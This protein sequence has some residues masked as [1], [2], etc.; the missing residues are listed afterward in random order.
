MPRFSMPGRHGSR[1]VPQGQ[2]ADGAGGYL[3]LAQNSPI[4]SPCSFTHAGVSPH[5]RFR[6]FIAGCTN[7]RAAGAFARLWAERSCTSIPMAKS[8]VAR[9]LPNLALFVASILIACGIGELLVRIF[10]K[11][12]AVLFPRYHTA[13]HYDAFVLRGVRPNATFWHESNEGRWKFVT[14]ARGLRDTRNFPYEKPDSIL[15][16]L[17]LGDS[18][19]QGY[20]TDQDSTFSAVLERFLNARRRPAQVL[21]A[22]VSG[23]SNAE[24]LAYLEH[25]GVRYHP[26]VVVLGFYANDLL[27]NL[28]ADLYRLDDHDALTLHRTTYIPGVRALEIV[29]MVPLTDYLSQH[30]YLYSLVFNDVWEFVKGNDRTV[31]QERLASEYTVA[32][33]STATQTEVRLAAATIFRMADILAKRSIGFIVLDIPQGKG[34]FDFLASLPPALSD[35]LAAHG[36][37]CI[38]PDSVLGSYRGIRRFHH[39]GGPHHITP[40]VHERLGIALGEEI[41]RMRTNGS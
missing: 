33:E 12:N 5:E 4:I 40:F 26:D 29:R 11:D 10:L 39:P 32:V 22:G 6:L 17:C 3:T 1:R 31:A 16:V 36:I 21:N 41:L 14:N 2:G 35:S 15:R 37:Q 27:D 18:Q 25:E 34:E 7:E 13:Y 23:F 28:R 8:T 20:E 30:S 24:A 38:H 19:T 9:F